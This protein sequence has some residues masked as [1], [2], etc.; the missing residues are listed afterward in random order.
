M[1]ILFKFIDDP[2]FG[3]VQ[4]GRDPLHISIGYASYY[5]NPCMCCCVTDV[6]LKDTVATV[7][8]ETLHIVLHKLRLYEAC[9]KL[10]Q[11]LDDDGVWWYDL[12]GIPENVL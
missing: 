8:H 7:S 9:V 3:F 6:A 4:L 12:S 5:R 11:L 2:N 1:N 10:D